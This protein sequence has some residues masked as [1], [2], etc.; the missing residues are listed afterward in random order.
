MGVAW[1]NL[2]V[3]RLSHRYSRSRHPALCDVSFDVP[4]GRTL[5]VIGPSGAGKS[6]LLR[7]VSG[8]IR[9]TSGEIALGSTD[10]GERSAQ[11]RRIALVF[12]HDALFP[13]MSVRANLSF[14]VRNRLGLQRI[15]PLA[16]LF[17]IAAHLDRMPAVLSGG[18]RQR[19]AIVRALLSEPAVLLLDEP[20]A[21]L[22]PE[23]RAR[24]R[25]ELVRVRDCFG[26]PIVYV[27]HDHS[28]AFAVADELLVLVAGVIEDT[29]DPQR[30]Y[31]APRTSRTAAFLGDRAMNLL[32]GIHDGVV[33]GI[34]PEHVRLDPHGR[35]SGRIIR[36]EATGPHA[37]VYVDTAAGIIAARIGSADAAAT[38]ADVRLA[39]EEC[40][41]CL[42][43]RATGLLLE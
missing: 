25:N 29:G 6:T 18:E 38:G 42:F 21:H 19:V 13:H 23:L 41:V 17:D 10:I 24:L 2:R 3:T 7:I 12:Q 14:A 30:I 28:E 4:A 8:L 16:R 31:D 26:G 32:D 40:D 15:M 35:L 1:E 11:E 27:T 37:Y 22:D 39:F 9:G 43:D 34:R 5:A 36:R 20:L 33:T